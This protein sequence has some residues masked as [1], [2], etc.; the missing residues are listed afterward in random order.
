MVYRMVSKTI[1]RKTVRVRLPLSAPNMAI[2]VNDLRN[3]A[4]FQDSQGVWQ[5]ETFEHIKMGRGSA[6]IKVKA[7]N[8]RSGAIA[9]KSFISGNKVEEA[10]VE[11]RKV[12]YLYRDAGKFY[13]M[14]PAS[15]DQFSIDQSKSPSL[16]NFIKEGEP[17]EILLISG[18]PVAV[19]MPKNVI[20][21]I[22][23][24]APGERGNTVSNLNKEA[25]VETGARVSVPLFIKTGDRIKVDT[26]S[27]A[28]VERA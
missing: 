27:G 26:R 3:G 10:E 22:T 19:E 8:L 9:E 24:A 16:P 7:R 2:P 17:V 11:K 13:I 1:G 25:T 18:E 21:T 15:F 12:Q 14:D 23:E 5:V 4:T 20:L 28:Y 6:T